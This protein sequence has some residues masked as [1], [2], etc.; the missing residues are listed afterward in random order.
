MTIRAA[1]RAAGAAG[2]LLAVLVAACTGDRGR[3]GR[4]TREKITLEPVAS[5]GVPSGD[6]LRTFGDVTD[7]AAD[8]AG[9]LYVLDAPAQRVRVFD[10]GGA[11]LGELGRAG[12]GP[13]EFLAPVALAVD[14]DD[15]LYVLDPMNQRLEVFGPGPAG[16]RWTRSIRLGFPA[17]DV[18]AEGSRLYLLGTGEGRPIQEV[19]PD[20]VPIRSFGVSPG[21]SDPMLSASLAGGYL[22]CF[23]GSILHLAM[24]TPELRGYS[25]DGSGGW[26]AGIPGYEPVEVESHDGSVTFTVGPS[27]VH[28]VAGAAAG[29]TPEWGIVQVG[30][31]PRGARGPTELVRIKSYVVSRRDGRI[32]RLPASLPRILGTR[33]GLAFGAR[34]DPF[35]H[36]EVYR[37]TRDEGE[38]R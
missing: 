18:C 2:L 25:P 15:R 34:S 19:A 22:A 3:Q 36:V 5:I 29:L 27:G 12:R 8:R 1:R 38:R 17:G 24:L 23:G 21:G 6:S 20:G 10:R 26:K 35:P 37:I 16:H 13:G 14:A 33:D 9:N 30:V 4:G 11:F 32:R 7:V 31:L 28:D